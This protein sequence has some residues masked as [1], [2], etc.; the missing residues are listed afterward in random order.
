VPNSD[1][2]DVAVSDPV[3]Y[4]YEVTCWRDD[5]PGALD[6][7]GGEWVIDYARQ[8]VE[9]HGC[10]LQVQVKSTIDVRPSQAATDES[11]HAREE[12]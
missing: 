6:T 12:G 8:H 11:R 7:Y 10:T 4:R 3:P 5:C 2:F 1:H 9:K